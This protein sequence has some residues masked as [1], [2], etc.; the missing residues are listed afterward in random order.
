MWGAVLER[1]AR[2]ISLRTDTRAHVNIVVQIIC[3][4]FAPGKKRFLTEEQVRCSLGAPAWPACQLREKLSTL[5]H[6][7]IA[8]ETEKPRPYRAVTCG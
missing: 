7:Q 1:G 3:F 5:S 8:T 6:V 4:L 2:E